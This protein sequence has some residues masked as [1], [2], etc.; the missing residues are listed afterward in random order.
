MAATVGAALLI[1]LSAC[2]P[3]GTSSAATSETPSKDLSSDKVTLTVVTTPESGAPLDKIIA[4]FEKKHPN[5]MVVNKKTTFDDYNKQLPLQLASNSSPDLALINF[6]GNMAKDKLLLPLNPYKKLY[7]WDKV[8]SPGE[9]GDYSMQ[10]NLVGA[11]GSDLVA[12]PTSF[13]LVGVYYNKALAKQA[14]ISIPPTSYED[15][16]SDLAKAKSA[17]LLPLQL[18]NAQG[19]AFFTIQEIGQSIDGAD[20]ARDWVWGKSGNTFDTAGNRKGVQSL[21]E[22]NKVGYIPSSTEVNGTD[23]ADAVGKFTSGKGTFFVDGNWD[24]ATIAKA[25]G[26]N[27]GFFT[28][29]G[30]KATGAGGSAAYAISARSKHPNAAAAFLDFFQSAEASQA[31]FDSGFLPKNVSALTPPSS[32]VM[33]DILTN[34]AKVSSDNGGVDAYANA[35]ASM[36]DT[37]IKTTQDLLS[38]ATDPNTLITTVQADWA[39]SHG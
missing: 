35:T 13:Y 12:L 16:V 20:K 39:K 22:W 3:G 5:I 24:G 8:Y 7:G 30:Q 14:G 38:G 31:E 37:L 6:V 18:G 32:P 15:F 33:S 4:A 10:D 9:L 29:P 26:D 28:F 36:N 1:T 11:G 23:L 17:G 25:M 19:H 27:V 2:A 34:F 21:V